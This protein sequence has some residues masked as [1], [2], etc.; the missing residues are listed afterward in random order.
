[1]RE[2]AQ[3][4]SRRLLVEGRVVIT[5]VAGSH[6][7]ARVRGDGVIHDVTANGDAWSCS[8]PARGRCSHLLA[9]G[10]VVATNRSRS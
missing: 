2:D 3:T 4:K 8:C 6:V 9:V 5:A 10:H 7:E 1:M